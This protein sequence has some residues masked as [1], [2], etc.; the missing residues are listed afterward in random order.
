MNPR[1]SARINAEV[2]NRIDRCVAAANVANPG[3]PIE[4]GGMV[5]VLLLRALPAQEAESGH[6]CQ[7]DPPKRSSPN[8]SDARLPSDS[9]TDRIVPLVI[10]LR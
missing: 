9:D 1:V 7:T 8:E 6:A 5:R 2:L 10:G 4:R 3:H